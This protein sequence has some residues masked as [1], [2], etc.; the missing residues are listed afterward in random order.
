MV[1]C[2]WNLSSGSHCCVLLSSSSVSCSFH[3]LVKDVGDLVHRESFFHSADTFE[4]CP[5]TCVNNQVTL[6]LVY[7]IYTTLYCT[8]TYIHR[9][10]AMIDCSW[11]EWQL[12][13]LSST[14]VFHWDECPYQWGYL[15]VPF[16]VNLIPEVITQLFFDWTWRTVRAESSWETAG[17]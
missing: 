14:A 2:W 3:H 13:V 5:F 1:T 7:I 12:T 9:P 11:H 17:S 8:T 6:D 4:R 10:D 16:V 15:L